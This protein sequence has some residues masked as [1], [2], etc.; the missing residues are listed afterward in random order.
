MRGR[1]FIQAC[2]LLIILSASELTTLSRE[3][4]SGDYG[5]EVKAYL[6]FLRHEEAE[7]EFQIRNDEIPRKNYVR[8][9]NR[10]AILRQKVLAIV[11][12]TGKDIVPELSVVTLSEID[13]LIEDGSRLVRRAK[14]GT[15][16]AEKWLYHGSVSRGEIFHVFE[17]I[18]K[19]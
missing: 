15:V 13:Q 9:K 4:Q 2:L 18:T 8:A 3:V 11:K 16:L 10:I 12:E 1:V 19:K 7:L 17:R 6:D 14:P 5:P